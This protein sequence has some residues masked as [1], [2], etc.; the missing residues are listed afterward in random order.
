MASQ[1]WQNVTSGEGVEFLAKS[2]AG[3]YQSRTGSRAQFVPLVLWPELE[4][5][6]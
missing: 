3:N 4:Y 2:G 6:K 1:L 5:R